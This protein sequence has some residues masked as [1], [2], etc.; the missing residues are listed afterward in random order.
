MNTHIRVIGVIDIVL[1]SVTALGGVAL[2]IAFLTGALTLDGAS[3]AAAGAIMGA[4]L[5]VSTFLI[6][7]G[8][9]GIVVGIKL[10]DHENWARVTQII[11]GVL[12]LFNFPLG[13]AFGVYSLWAMLS[14][15]GRELF[16]DQPERLRR[17]A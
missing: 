2:L 3:T 6:A 9:L 8:I 5:F 17:A 7:V 13:T 4:S 1:G 16:Q 12:Q 10:G 14:E 15:E 11:F